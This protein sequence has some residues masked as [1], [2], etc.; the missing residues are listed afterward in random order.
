MSSVVAPEEF[1]LQ[2][3]SE[4]IS[5]GL[6]LGTVPSNFTTPLTDVDEELSGTAAATSVSRCPEAK[7]ASAARMASETYLL[8]I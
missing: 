6:G 4:D 5:I 2:L 8:F 1:D 3:G 7:A